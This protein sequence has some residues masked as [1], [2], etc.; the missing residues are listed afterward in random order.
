MSS[1]FATFGGGQL[2]GFNVA[3]P[4]KIAVA[5]EGLTEDELR[6]ELRKEPF[7]NEYCTTY[8]MNK[9]QDMAD[10]YDMVLV[11]LDELISYNEN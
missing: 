4:M 3:N 1:H 6:A 8:P 11:D 10:K 7:N 9:F 5:K 2:Q